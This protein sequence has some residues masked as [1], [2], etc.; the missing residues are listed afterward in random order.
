[1]P[2]ATPWPIGSGHLAFVYATRMNLSPRE[3]QALELLGQ[4]L[5]PDEIAREMVASPFTVGVLLENVRLKSLMA[6]AGGLRAIGE[7]VGGSAR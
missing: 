3:R 2:I 7:G 4:S 1:M 6:L 5:T